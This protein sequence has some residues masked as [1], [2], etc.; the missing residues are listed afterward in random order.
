M[1]SIFFN[2]TDKNAIPEA[3]REQ[4]VKVIKDYLEIV[5]QKYKIREDEIIQEL[6]KIVDDK[7]NADEL[8][9]ILIKGRNKNEY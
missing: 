5:K 1:I 2:G 3:L 8:F 7:E 4:H 6:Q 9:D